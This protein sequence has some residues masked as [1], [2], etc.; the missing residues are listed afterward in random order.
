MFYFKKKTFS[1]KKKKSN[2]SP[3]RCHVVLRLDGGLE[4]SS[5]LQMLVVNHS[6]GVWRLV[7]DI[8]EFFLLSSLHLLE[9]I[10][11]GCEWSCCTTQALVMSEASTFAVWKWNPPI[12]Q[13]GLELQQEAGF[14][15]GS[16]RGGSR[17]QRSRKFSTGDV[18][19]YPRQWKEAATAWVKTTACSP[20]TCR[21]S[22]S[23]PSLESRPDLKPI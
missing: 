16:G 8:S 14:Q 15:F 4:R 6:S 5:R 22:I 11:H 23:T 9:T 7:D 21:V 20:L 1:L 10:W 17:S 13:R 18:L 2:F 3:Q 19:G 12:T